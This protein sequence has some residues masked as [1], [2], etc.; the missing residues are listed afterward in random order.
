MANLRLRLIGVSLIL[1][2]L[3][4]TPMAGIL[5]GVTAA[6][7]DPLKLG[8]LELGRSL[9]TEVEFFAGLRRLR[10][11][12]YDLS[13]R[14]ISAEGELGRLREVVRENVG[15]RFELGLPDREVLKIK[16]LGEVSGKSTGAGESTI[17]VNRGT[18]DGIGV[19]DTAVWQGNLVGK[20]I[21]TY[22]TT[23][24]VRLITD[25]GS[26]VAALDQTSADRT[27][28]VVRGQYGTSLA[29]EKILPTAQ[30]VIEDRVVTSGEDG[31]FPKGL[32]VGKVT[33]V[34]ASDVDVL[35]KA[36]LAP[37]LD[38]QNIEAVLFVEE[39]K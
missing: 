39:K 12:N 6:V 1:L 21:K 15:L 32:L 31:L 10:D 4:L 16:A 20:V 18:R 22:P 36:T 13:Q 27:R 29:M 11:E 17:T 25:P 33:A 14:L 2:V 35:K 9:K 24:L 26:L 3:G 30:I 38:L 19:G 23:S 28:G 7:S 34:I 37:L 8:L 5:R